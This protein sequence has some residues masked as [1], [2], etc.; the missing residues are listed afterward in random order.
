MTYDYLL[1]AS[2]RYHNND[3]DV[4]FTLYRMLVRPTPFTVQGS[5]S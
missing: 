3:R 2:Y 5:D 4:M 1:C